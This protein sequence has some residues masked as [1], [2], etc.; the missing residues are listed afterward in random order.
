MHGIEKVIKVNDTHSFFLDLLSVLPTD[1]PKEV[2]EN[3]DLLAGIA[4][5]VAERKKLALNGFTG[6][7]ASLSIAPTGF[8][9]G[10][11]GYCYAK[12]FYNETEYLTPSLLQDFVDKYNIDIQKGN[13][14]IY[15]GEPVFNFE[16]CYDLV[17]YLHEV[18][19]TQY[20][21]VVTSLFYNDTTFGHLQDFM[22]IFPRMTL[23][24]SLDSI[25]DNQRKYKAAEDNDKIVDSASFKN[26]RSHYFAYERLKT[27]VKLFP[28][29]VNV[30]ST[31]NHGNMYWNW[32]NIIESELG[33]EN[34]AHNCD[35]STASSPVDMTS[36]IEDFNT[37]IEKIWY[38]ENN[39][40]YNDFS[41]YD[42]YDTFA[43]IIKGCDVNMTR[44]AVNHKGERIM[45]VDNLLSTWDPKTKEEVGQYIYN[46][47]GEVCKGC[48]AQ[49]LCF[50]KCFYVFNENPCKWSI[51]KFTKYLEIKGRTSEG[52][53]DLINKSVV[54]I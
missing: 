39:P 41:M 9:P 54:K 10:R 16:K 38:T 26:Y 14:I 37:Y 40:F 18:L 49:N 22:R 45:C 3:K 27:L 1:T 5:R 30:R 32:I 36:F 24:V 2:L 23:S 13:A 53:Q 19:N 51:A 20:V 50:S 52:L 48:N 28:K 34:F 8:C 47:S 12:D 11:C 25:Y 4:N 6:R 31:I 35:W 15:G 44:L 7:P 46:T 42:T 29:R 33:Y 21:C 17:Y 43:G